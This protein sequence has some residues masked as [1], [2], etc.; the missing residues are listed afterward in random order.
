LDWI[1]PYY[2]FFNLISYFMDYAI[3]KHIFFKNKY[4]DVQ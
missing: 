2:L 1:F 3:Q 4:V